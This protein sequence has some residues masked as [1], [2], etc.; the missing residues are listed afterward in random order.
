MSKEDM[1]SLFV[2]ETRNFVGKILDATDD[3][4]YTFIAIPHF[5]YF[6]YVYSYA[7]GQIISRSL[8][9]KYKANNSFIEKVEEFLKSGQSASPRDIFLKTGIDIADPE[10]IQAG[11]DAISED[12]KKYDSLVNKVLSNRKA[13]K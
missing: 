7:L 10:F 12:L 9:A 2:K 13:K 1:A 5:R 4:G 6:F 3:D 8:C 11:I